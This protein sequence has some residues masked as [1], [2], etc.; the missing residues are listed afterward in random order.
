MR[1]EKSFLYWPAV[2][3]LMVLAWWLWDA[4]QTTEDRLTES[5]LC[6]LSGQACELDL[7][8][9]ETAI[10]LTPQPVPVEEEIQFHL[11][12]PSGFRLAKGHIVGENM[13]MGRIPLLVQSQ[14]QKREDNFSEWTAISFLGSCSEPQ[15]LWRVQLELHAPSGQILERDFLFTTTR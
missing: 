12:L 8:E 6:N 7:A 9:E 4:R 13:Y 2:G 11:R 1:V 10:W 3:A 5:T 15:M 14:P